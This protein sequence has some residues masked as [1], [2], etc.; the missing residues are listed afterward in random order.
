MVA[1]CDEEN[2]VLFCN[3]TNRATG[4]KPARRNENEEASGATSVEIGGLMGIRLK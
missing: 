1:K 4:S 2:M 3:V